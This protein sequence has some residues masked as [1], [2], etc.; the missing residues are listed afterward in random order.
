MPSP[1]QTSLQPSTQVFLHPQVTQNSSLSAQNLL[2]SEIPNPTSSPT[3]HGSST[4]AIIGGVVGTF[5]F[6]ALITVIVLSIPFCI[7]KRKRRGKRLLSCNY[8]V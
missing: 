4:E 2:P 8:F 5:L 1:T 3:S 6:V 7:Y